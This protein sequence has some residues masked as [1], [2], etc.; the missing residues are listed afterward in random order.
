MINYI[1]AS[2][3]F[4]NVQ[5][6]DTVSYRIDPGMEWHRTEQ[7]K[8]VKFSFDFSSF[9]YDYF[10]NGNDVKHYRRKYKLIIDF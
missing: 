5:P 3:L 4:F 2:L 10:L 9:I 8:K 7:V 6:I 1:F